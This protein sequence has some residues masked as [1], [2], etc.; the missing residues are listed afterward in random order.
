MNSQ[1]MLEQLEG[2]AQKL[3]VRIRYERC[4]S[5]GGLCRVK[6]DQ[7]ILVRKTLTIPEKVEVLGRALCRFSLEET[8]L[9]PEVRRFLEAM[10]STTEED[11]DGMVEDP[12]FCEESATDRV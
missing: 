2:L 6:D 9:M 11:V 12:P 3:S 4:R 8:Y 1:E 7:M 5:R 10:A